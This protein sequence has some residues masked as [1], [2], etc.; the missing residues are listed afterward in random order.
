[1]SE[2]KDIHDHVLFTLGAMPNAW[3]CST[4]GGLVMHEKPAAQAALDAQRAELREV[5]TKV[6]T[7][8]AMEAVE[9]L[10]RLVQD[11][12]RRRQEH[13]YIEGG[14]LIAVYARRYDVKSP[15]AE[16]TKDYLLKAIESHRKTMEHYCPP[17][18]Q[19]EFVVTLGRAVQLIAEWGVLLDALT[20]AFM[21][22]YEEAWAAHDRNKNWPRTTPQL[23]G[24][25]Q[26]HAAI[27][28]AL[29]RIQL[30]GAT[31]R[32]VR[33]EL[34]LKEPVHGS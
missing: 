17:K 15:S 4:C 1:M 19:V 25:G 32:Y 16:E 22:G 13:A 9:D 3:Y 23:F 33:T 26:K 29:G 2:S 11:E 31:G 6:Q 7:G 20:E 21:S 10:G 34:P 28:A 8:A 30:D 18:S 14:G 5:N 12:V 24:A 27:L